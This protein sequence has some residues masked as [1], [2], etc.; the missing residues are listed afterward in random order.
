MSATPDPAAAA[1]DPLAAV[2]ELFGR[3][4]RGDAA[5]LPELRRTLDE[6][7]ETWAGFGDLA[8]HA[9]AAW[10]RLVAGQNLL[11]HESL[12]R[13]AEAL[14]AEVAGADATPLERLLAERVAATWLQINY[15][16]A[17]Y[18]QYTGSCAVTLRE[19]L[20]RQEAAER[21]HQAAVKQ[22]ALVRKLLRRAPSPLELLRPTADAAPGVP[23]VKLRRAGSPAVGVPVAN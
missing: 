8:A 6:H 16:D 3:A 1:A 11:L 14:G 4:A 12:L 13:K 2:R 19:L 23:P 5:V 18:A 21:R 20:R 10:I 15:A 7:P 17:T 9:Q 22:L